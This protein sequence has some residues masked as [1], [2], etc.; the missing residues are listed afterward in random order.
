MPNILH[1]HMEVVDTFAPSEETISVVTNLLV[2]SGFSRD[3]LRLSPNKINASTSEVE[4]L[5]NTEYHI[6]SHP[7]GNTQIGEERPYFYLK[8]FIHSLQDA[9]TILCP[10]IFDRMS[11]SSNL[12]YTL[13]SPTSP[14]CSAKAHWRPGSTLLR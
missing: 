5:L 7:S 11:I 1:L 2:D 6:Y 3:R 13:Q 4:N 9:T 10:D 12:L 14:K 8:I